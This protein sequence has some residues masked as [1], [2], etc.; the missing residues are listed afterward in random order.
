VLPLT[1]DRRDALVEAVEAVYLGDTH[2]YVITMERSTEIV[3]KGG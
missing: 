3:S 2:D 1:R